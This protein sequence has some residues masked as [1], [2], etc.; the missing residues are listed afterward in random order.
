MPITR[1][2]KMIGTTIDLIIRRKMVESGLR[3]AASSGLSQPTS[4]PI[5]MKI[6]IHLVTEILRR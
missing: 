4:A 3:L 5:T 1:L 2:P 6:R